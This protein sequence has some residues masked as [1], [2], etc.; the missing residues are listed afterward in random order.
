MSG[1]VEIPRHAATPCKHGDLYREGNAPMD[2]KGMYNLSRLGP[3][4]S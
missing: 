4:R 1:G 3:A 2:A